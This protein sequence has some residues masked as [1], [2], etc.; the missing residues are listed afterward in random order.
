M[1]NLTGRQMGQY[2]IV[3][4]LGEG[5][6]AAVYKAY[7][8][9]MDRYVALKILPSHF[10]NDP[11]FTYRFE[12]EAKLI[13]NLE[14]P[15]ILPVYDFGQA[16]GYSYIVMRF[17]VGGTLA[18]LLKG[19]PLPLPQACG[20]LSKIASALDYA[21]SRG[22]IHRDVKP[23]NVL[24][25]EQGNCLLSD[26][27]LA[28]VILSDSRFTASG[29][30]IGTPAYA[31]PEQCLGGE[32]D[33]RSDVYS[34]G[35]MLYEMAT[36]RTPYE[37]ETPMAIVVKTIHD[38]LPPPSTINP[39]LSEDIERVILKA[40]AKAPE[41]RY[42]SA[43][44]L[45]RALEAVV[46]GVP[47]TPLVL[48]AQAAPAEKV[49]SGSRSPQPAISPAAKRKIPIW[50][51]AAG[52]A[53]LFILLA[54]AVGTVLVVVTLTKPSSERA[55]VTSTARPT[56]TRVMLAAAPLVIT[57]TIVAQAA[58]VPME[59]VMVV[60]LA[61]ESTAAALLPA[62]VTPQ[63]PRLTA[64]AIPYTPAPAGSWVAL[65][66]LP[67]AI[68]S[69]VWDPA[70]P[71]VVYAGTGDY[72]GSGSG[73]YKSEDGGM[74]WRSAATGLPYKAVLAL[75]IAPS[76]PPVLYALAYNE[77][78][79]SNDGAQTWVYRG[80]VE[81]FT[82]S[83][84]FQLLPS[85]DG[86]ALFAVGGY[87]LPLRSDDN[88]QTWVSFGIGLPEG[89]AGS[90]SACVIALDPSDANIF[91]AGT[92]SSGVYKS[93]D[94]GWTFAPSNKGMLDYGISALAIDPADPKIIYAGGS[95]G[96]LFKS[97]D[98][99]QNWIN[100][101]ELLQVQNDLYPGNIHGIKLHPAEAGTLYLFADNSGL[102]ISRDNGNTW[103]RL[104]SPPGK[105]QSWFMSVGIALDPQL[106]LI[107][108]VE[109]VGGWRY[110][111]GAVPVEPTPTL[112]PVTAVTA[113][114]LFPAGTWQEVTE[115]PREI[116]AF[117]LDPANP[118][119]L[120]ACTGG[121]GQGGSV[122]KSADGGL[123]WQ[124]SA[125][126]L[127]EDGVTAIA[128]SQDGNL[129]ALSSTGDVFGSTDG[130]ESWTILSNTG[131]WGGFESWLVVAPQNSDVIYSLA[132]TANWFGRSTDGGRSW[133]DV[134][135]GLPQ[136]DYEVYV[137]SLAIDP[138]DANVVYAGTGG[139]VGQGYGVYKSP[140]GGESWVPS[141]QGM[142]DYVITAL[143]IDPTDPQVIYAGGNF[144]EL[145]KSIDGGQTW[146]NLTIY[147]YGQPN[148]P[149]GK[150]AGIAIDPS[151]PARVLVV[152]GYAIWYTLDGGITWQK[153]SKPGEQDQPIFTAWAVHF[154]PQP[155]LVVAV[156][157][158]G[159][160]IYTVK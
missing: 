6:M 1:E 31:S 76:A 8:P 129:F 2:R 17:V 74:S 133:V 124:Q 102:M 114:P 70:N 53:G 150:I 116:N 144:G 109:R 91:Y 38:P 103:Q 125:S 151:D 78:Y 40:L 62:T 75:A 44:D 156:D 24:I 139:F 26:F 35:V 3:A 27:G 134:K 113:G 9:S 73:V 64:T 106:T 16:D 5:G 119:I 99:G 36:G 148:M 132:N 115:L 130:A 152:G 65:A 50:G 19:N 143:A 121:L 159:A 118:Q 128:V 126:G 158:S 81:G 13:A 55:Q 72:A 135:N 63:P 23:S 7:Q 68:N 58:S 69:V 87:G 11:N 22:V 88:G 54:F 14:H 71:Q 83:G 95:S 46:G 79:A 10:A 43:G 39:L 94:G 157:S 137:S 82:G 155:V 92:A 52:C 112:A 33:H 56:K 41:D 141:N 131:M 34:L 146:Y 77:V 96:E 28:K 12:R 90:I 110:S 61:V 57:Q 127:S 108:A 48:P 15:N 117:L 136:A 86:K 105:E 20:I 21:H 149:G 123:T 140:N 145:F 138:S 49:S 122:Y 37:A 59:T 32:L 100:L 45:V 51:W 47:T 111:I 85:T 147:L 66:D 93:I 97:T 89:G 142:L 160:W 153:F 18:D 98:A 84:P 154:G 101:T 67:R 42:Q 25:D 107:T 60:T 104:G 30:F 120:F 29:A 4:P 80:N